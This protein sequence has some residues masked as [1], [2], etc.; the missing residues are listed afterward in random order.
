VKAVKYAPPTVT[1]PVAGFAEFI[2]NAD[3]FKSQ[4]AEMGI[5]TTKM[6]LGD[7]SQKTVISAP[8][9]ALTQHLSTGFRTTR[10]DLSGPL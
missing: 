2:T 5:D 6:P 3:M 9:H 4:L 1:G 8:M 10:L 7:I